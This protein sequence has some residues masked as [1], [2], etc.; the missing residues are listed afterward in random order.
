MALLE[1][2][3]KNEPQKPLNCWDNWTC[4]ERIWYKQVKD[5]PDKN[6][7]GCEITQ[8]EVGRFC[9][10]MRRYSIT[11]LPHCSVCMYPVTT[12]SHHI[13]GDM[14]VSDLVGGF[15]SYIEK[16]LRKKSTMFVIDSDDII[17]NNKVEPKEVEELPT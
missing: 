1:P 16:K 17:T 15:K 6:E 3:K 5:P 14:R 10:C 2:Q 7:Y 11:A 4:K 12:W 8:I 13:R 9:N